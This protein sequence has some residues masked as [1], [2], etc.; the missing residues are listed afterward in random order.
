MKISIVTPSYNQGQFLE[1]TIDSILSQS[2]PNLDYIIIDGGSTDNS[3]E[4]IKKYEKHLAYWVSEK[5]R[6][7]SH[8][9]NKGFRKATGEI[10]NWINSDDILAPGSLDALAQTYF[11]SKKREIANTKHTLICGSAGFVY[12]EDPSKNYNIELSAINLE[13]MI[14]YWRDICSWEQPCMFFPLELFHEVGGCDETEEMAMDYD[15]WCRMLQSAEVKYTKHPVA[16]IRRHKAA[17][18][19]KWNYRCW[20]VNKLISKRHWHLLSFDPSQE[21]KKT[22][23]EHCKHWIRKLLKQKQFKAALEMYWE[24]I[25]T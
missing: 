16:N 17:K 9:I 5:D 10:G 20:Q 3:V 15:L 13:N 24:W 8:A 12:E 7:Q 22:Y 21:F 6:G 18:T 1:E 23:R 2:Y 4:I 19:C 25:T 14:C 11:D